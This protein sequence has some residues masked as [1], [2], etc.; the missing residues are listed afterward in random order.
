MLKRTMLAALCICG[1]AGTALL[2]QESATL[3]LRAGERIQGQLIDLGGV[4]FT[5][6]V[7]GQERRIPANDVAAIEFQSGGRLT[8]D[9]HNRLSSG[10]PLI[11]LKNG[12]IFEGRLTDIHGAGSSRLTVDTNSGQRE[13]SAGEVAQIY[14]SVPPGMT[15]PSAVATSGVQGTTLESGA[16]SVP[17][18]QHWVATG[19]TVRK[20]QI[21]N[22]RTSGQI[23]MSTDSNDLAQ[24]AGSTNGRKAKGAPLPDALAGALIGRI[25]DGPAFAIGNQTS[26]PMP[27]NGQLFLGIND[28]EVSD[29]SGNFSVVINRG[30]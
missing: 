30:R 27:A 12:Q 13:I 23:Q 16:I 8:T 28:D 7:N 4:G 2:A 22:F 1:L 15:A 10:Q 3:V 9:W 24:S 18:N 5:L 20:G 11:V 25:G 6:G 14:F 17:G 29:N 19:I 21:L 26:V